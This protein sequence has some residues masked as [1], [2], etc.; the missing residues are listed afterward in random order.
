M[1]PPCIEGSM[2]LQSSPY[3]LSNSSLASSGTLEQTL[4]DLVGKCKRGQYLLEKLHHDET[5][6]THLP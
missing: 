1:S 4:P 2:F 6:Y 5:C 3:N